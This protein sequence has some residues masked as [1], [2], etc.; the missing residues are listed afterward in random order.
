VGKVSVITIAKNNLIG[1]RST[2]GSLLR[3]SFLDWEMIIVV[4]DS[5]DG[6]LTFARTL[7]SEDSRIRLIEQ[8][9][10]GIYEAM[11]EGL[12]ITVGIYAW[13]MNA[14]DQFSSETV[15]GT[16]VNE[17]SK[18]DFGLVIGSHKIQG[19][20]QNFSNRYPAGKVSSV[21]FAFNRGAGCHQA[22]IFRTT[23]LKE[24]GGFNLS[25]SLASDFDLVMRLLKVSSATKV[26][27]VYADIEPGGIADRKIYQVHREKHQIRT[28]LLGGV[29]IFIASSIWTF[30]AGSKIILRNILS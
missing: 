10:I 4:G 17:I 12:G 23:I 24:I 13:F 29:P 2:H 9:G 3:Q 1:L 22:M 16:A 15:L 30:L 26:P 28:R 25:Y 21:N 5:S 27:D 14:G 8:K 18:N 11:N 6:T 7:Q 19:S 20:T